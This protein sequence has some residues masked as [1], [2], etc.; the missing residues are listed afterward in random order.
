MCPVGHVLRDV[1]LKG[2]IP[3]HD[4]DMNSD[5]LSSMAS[6]EERLH[7]DAFEALKALQKAHDSGCSLNSALDVAIAITEA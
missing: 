7:P 4:S 2:Y 3:S 5:S 1:G 6:I